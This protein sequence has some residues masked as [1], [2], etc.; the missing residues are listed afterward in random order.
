[1]KNSDIEI[2]SKRKGLKEKYAKTESGVQ[3]VE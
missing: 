3:T 1:M 2:E